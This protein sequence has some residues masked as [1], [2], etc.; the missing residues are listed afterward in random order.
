MTDLAHPGVVTDGV[1]ELRRWRDEDVAAVRAAQRGTSE[2]ALAWVRRQQTRAP[3]V[4][5]SCAVAQNGQVAAGYV[6]LIRRPRVELGVTRA[7]DDGELVF[8]AHQRIV[9][10][11][12]WIAPD[13]QRH[14]LATRATGLL[15]C[16]ALQSAGMIRIEALVERHNV[17][18]RRVVEKSGFRAEGQLRSYLNLDGHTTDA[19]VYSLLQSDL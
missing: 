6:G 3:A 17:A 16:W 10:I 11:G 5:V 2:E 8:K 9:G 18:S 1:V 13:A 4:G 12:F 7:L 14:G 19:Q 15:S